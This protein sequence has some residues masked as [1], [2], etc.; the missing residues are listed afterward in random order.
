MC[1]EKGIRLITIYDKFPKGQTVPFE[2]DVYT[3]V[4]DLNIA[5]H[6]IIRSLIQKLFSEVGLNEKIDDEE[7]E[8]I[9]KNAY[10]NAKSMTHDMLFQQTYFPEIV[11]ESVELNW[12]M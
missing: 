10:S 4:E 2:N 9:E 8:Q 12:R 11:A 7:W 6:S 1:S 3:F 5:N